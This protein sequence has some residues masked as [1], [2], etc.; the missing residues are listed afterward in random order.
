MGQTLNTWRTDTGEL[1]IIILEPF[2]SPRPKHVSVV[3]R[4][5]GPDGPVEKRSKVFPFSY[6]VPPS[7]SAAGRGALLNIDVL[8]AD[9]ASQLD[10]GRGTSVGSVV[11]PLADQ[12][13]ALDAVEP[14][15]TVDLKVDEHSE[16]TGAPRFWCTSLLLG[17][18]TETLVE[19]EAQLRLSLKMAGSLQAPKLLVACGVSPVGGLPGP[20]LLRLVTQLEGSLRVLH[21]DF[22]ERSAPVAAARL[23]SACS[24]VSTAEQTPS[25]SRRL[26]VEDATSALALHDHVQLSRANLSLK[27]TLCRE[28]ELYDQKLSQLGLTPRL[29]VV[30]STEEASEPA[31]D[32]DPEETRRRVHREYATAQENLQ[33]L[34]RSVNERRGRS[35]SAAST[36]RAISEKEALLKQYSRMHREL[37]DLR[38]S[39]LLQERKKTV[40]ETMIAEL[41]RD[42]ST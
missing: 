4:H 13:L 22:A 6:V 36:L 41:E 1:W 16:F 9:D 29:E 28:E 34:R 25:Q 21:K 17:I 19:A 2:L 39:S 40:L 14:H 18:T 27:Q 42:V 8:T 31:P 33:R 24:L 12:L 7:S 5:D 38:Q 15:C 30:A 23:S 10:R 35:E 3:L 26:S 37:E 11:L 32:D 20:G